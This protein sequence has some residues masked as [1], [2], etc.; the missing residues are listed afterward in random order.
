MDFLA[1]TREEEIPAKGVSCRITDSYEDVSAEVL[2][3]ANSTQD[4]FSKNHNNIKQ[5]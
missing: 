5:N 4:I 2:E 1:K 3:A